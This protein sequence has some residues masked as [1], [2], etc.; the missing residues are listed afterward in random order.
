MLANF[1]SE[2]TKISSKY[3][4]YASIINIYDQILVY[5]LNL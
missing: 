4:N 2:I 5:L 3:Q 1:L